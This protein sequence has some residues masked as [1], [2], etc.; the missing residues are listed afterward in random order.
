MKR[1]ILNVACALLFL[2][3][4]TN[5][6]SA[7]GIEA[8]CQFGIIAA[9]L[10]GGFSMPMI[11]STI[12]IL[13]LGLICDLNGIGP[14]GLYTFSFMVVFG[15]TRAIMTRLKSERVISLMIW[16]LLLCIL[17]EFLQA[18]L[19]SLFYQDTIFGGLFIRKF[20]L[21]ALLT[22]LFTPVMMWFEHLLERIF[23]RRKAS[24]LM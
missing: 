2:L 4:Q 3:I 6:N 14:L 21:D 9:V 17:F 8:I 24:G 11:S 5:I 1:A 13:I 22:S 7:F 20:W 15:I 16:S 12:S 18:T 10:S 23:T 19:Y